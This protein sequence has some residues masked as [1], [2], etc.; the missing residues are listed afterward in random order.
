MAD[1]YTQLYIHIVFTVKNRESL[2]RESFRVDLEKYICGIVSQKRHKPLAI[3]C[4]PDHT[5]LFVGLNPAEAISVL[6]RDIKTGSSAFI[7]EQNWL[8]GPFKWQEGYGAFSHARSQLDTV[9]RY[10]LNQPDHHRKRTFQEEYL[11]ML[12]KAG[13][14]YNDAY[15][16]D[17][18][19]DTRQ[20]PD[21]A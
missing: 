13:I 9:V 6:V 20:A 19:D 4:M 12:N 15:L 1:T 14:A 8:Q 5:H 17:W 7:K 10:I 3:Y 16:F 21:G 2:I 18:L 11:N